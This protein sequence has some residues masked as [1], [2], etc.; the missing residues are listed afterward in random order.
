MTPRD[1]LDVFNDLH[2]AIRVVIVTLP[3]TAIVWIAF[4]AR[5]DPFPVSATVRL[6]CV[7]TG[8]LYEFPRDRVKI[9]PAKSP[10]TGAYTLFPYREEGSSRYVDGRF[11]AMLESIKDKCAYVDLKS[12]AVK[13]Q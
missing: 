9:L 7:E 13:Q 12:L 5:G 11:R 6:V 3:L 2:P 10:S 1:T 8:Q 4:Y